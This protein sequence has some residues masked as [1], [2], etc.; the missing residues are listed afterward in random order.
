MSIFLNLTRDPD[1]VAMYETRTQVYILI[2]TFFILLHQVNRQESHI[3]MI[4]SH[5]TPQVEI[6]SY[7]IYLYKSFGKLYL[8]WLQLAITRP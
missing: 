8:Q 4:S 3:Y 7:A 5:D 1:E 6:F 2:F